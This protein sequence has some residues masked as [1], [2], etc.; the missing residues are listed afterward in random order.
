M[1]VSKK[2]L[3]YLLQIEI[4]FLFPIMNGVFIKNPQFIGKKTSGMMI[5]SFC[6]ELKV[7]YYHL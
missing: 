7:Q 2:I 3:F 6:F 5:T 1:W 4:C